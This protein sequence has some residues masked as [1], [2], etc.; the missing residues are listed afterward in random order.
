VLA[1]DPSGRAF[2]ALLACASDRLSARRFAEYLSLSE[3]PDADPSGTP[4]PARPSGD[5]GATPDE[6]TFPW[7][8]DHISEEPATNMP[9]L[10]PDAAVAGGSLRAPHRWERLIVDAA[11]IGGLDRW[12]RRLAGLGAALA[13]ELNS[14]ADPEESRVAAI[15]NRIAD[16]ESFRQ[17]A[18]P[19]LETL[20]TLQES[21][22][23]GVWIAQLSALATRALRT[24]DRVLSVLAELNPMAPV[25]PIT[26]REVRLVLARRL[27]ELVRPP[28]AKPYGRVFV[29]PIETTRGMSFAVAFVPGLAEKIFPQRVAEDPLFRDRERLDLASGL[30]TNETRIANER[31]ALKIAVGSARRRVILSFPRLDLELGRPRVPSFYGLEALRAGEGHL[32]GFEELLQRA[33]RVGEARIGWPAP[34]RS[35]EAIDESEYDLALLDKILR[36]PSEQTTGMARYLLESNVHLARALRFRA[37]RWRPKWTSADGLAEVS[38]AGRV[39]LDHHRLDRRSYSATQLQH[40]ATCPYRFVLSAVHGLTPREEPAAIE[41]LDPL[42][43]GSLV[44]EVLSRLLT[45]LR[46]KHLVPVRP[47]TL[48]QAREE[49]SRV[50]DEVAAHYHDD[51][52]PAIERLWT[53]TIGQIKADIV[54]MLRLASEDDSGW[55]PIRL[56]LAFGLRDRAGRDA[57]SSPEP[58]TLDCGVQLRGA[59]D[60]VEESA[61][62]ALRVTDFKTG[63]DRTKTGLVI[64]GGS[65]LQPALY[66]LAAEK[67]FPTRRV[68]AGRLYFCTSA[69]EFSETAVPLDGR[70]RTA[71]AAVAETIGHALESGFLVAAPA[72]KQACD[73]C[74]YAAVCGPGELRRVKRKPKDRLA[75]LARLRELE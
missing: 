36:L 14:F 43:R 9:L 38:T 17:Y 54:E 57:A 52:A 56:E 16:F 48:D 47:A 60:A 1:P 3:V 13:L 26:L 64:G 53:D 71:I 63:K 44:H 7:A 50:L 67:L 18:L 23:W 32:P 22:T 70:A 31:L 34:P 6:E 11:V 20:D 55:Q 72:D 5:S 39:A 58:V 27:T 30:E 10:D 8:P 15:K 66:A 46:D 25:G 65:V 4:P 42:Q 21:R 40:F 62:G 37:D 12:R 19:L 61:A 45:S 74:D 28:T 68:S 33:E 51:L 29:A 73:W 59:I 75:E 2:L 69:G 24:P 49:L 35:D 41:E